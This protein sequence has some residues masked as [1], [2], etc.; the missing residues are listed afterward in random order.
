MT[1]FQIADRPQ[2]GTWAQ[3]SVSEVCYFR[4][5]RYLDTKEPGQKGRNTAVLHAFGEH[6]FSDIGVP[7]YSDPGH[8]GSVVNKVL[9]GHSGPLTSRYLDTKV[10]GHS[11]PC[12]QRSA[13]ENQ[14]PPQRF[15][16]G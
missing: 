6:Q 5:Q 16:R 13:S 15:M 12:A 2:I 1:E 14:C 11:G 3:R 10:P 4:G 9:A 8:S 7:G